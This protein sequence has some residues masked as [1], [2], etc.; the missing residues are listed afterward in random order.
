LGD[1]CQG[2]LFKEVEEIEK[3]TS[4]NVAVFGRWKLA[5]NRIKGDY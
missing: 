3:E 5:R 2:T 4:E 1:F